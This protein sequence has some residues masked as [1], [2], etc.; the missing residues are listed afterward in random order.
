MNKK[1]SVL[2]L[3]NC[4][5]RSIK[6]AMQRFQAQADLSMEPVIVHQA[7]EQKESVLEKLAAADIIIT[8]RVDSKYP[9]EHVRTSEIRKNLTSKQRLHVFPTLYFSGYN[10]EIVYIKGPD[11]KSIYGLLGT[12]QDFNIWMAYVSGLDTE[13]IIKVGREDLGQFN[14][15]ERLNS[16]EAG[17]RKMKYLESECSIITSDIVEE[18]WADTQLFHVF[19]HPSN[20]LIKPVTQR[21]LT[22]AGIEFDSSKDL[23]VREL[24]YQYKI[25]ISPLVIPMLNS[26][27]SHD[28]YTVT[29]P[30]GAI[31]H[32]SWE[33]FVRES[34]V[35]FKKVGREFY[36]EA[37]KNVGNN[38]RTFINGVTE[39]FEL[40]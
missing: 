15:R 20:A 10:P 33:E 25:P 22:E 24:L 29:L 16:P 18:K 26:N 13:D 8:Q 21:L 23:G 28:S 1:P 17:I 2:L 31:R 9:I 39:G 38:D 36:I 30:S 34:M 37:R 7:E 4:Q 12:Y 32:L 14:P 19:G 3:A 40:Y 11:R 6:I 27:F 35:E 5:G